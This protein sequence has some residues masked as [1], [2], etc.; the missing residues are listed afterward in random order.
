MQIF[1]YNLK[2]LFAIFPITDNRSIIIHVK[3]VGTIEVIKGSKNTKIER[4]I[5]AVSAL[6]LS[7][8]TM[9]LIPFCHETL[10]K[11]K[12][13]YIYIFLFFFVGPYQL[14]SGFYHIILFIIASV[15]INLNH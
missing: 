9:A 11:K 15:G 3:N 7:F 13:I 8:L 6:Y 12:N 4:T 2:Q 14:A 1:F 5:S 10:K